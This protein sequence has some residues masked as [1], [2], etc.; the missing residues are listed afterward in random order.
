MNEWLAAAPKAQLFHGQIAC[1]V[2]LNDLSDR[3]PRVMTNGETLD[4]GNREIRWIDTPQVP[5]AWEAGVIYEEATRTLFCGDLLAQLGC[6]P[7]VV[8]TSL[9]P[10][11]IAAE[12]AFHPTALTIGTGATIR[13]LA[14]LQ[15][16]RLAVMHGSCFVGDGE[17]ILN[18][19][20]SYYEGQVTA[21]HGL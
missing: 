10:E 15:P 19:L 21:R 20:A 2:S 3:P 13:G 5:H 7:A 12:E 9:L 16:A 11:A 6:G 4:L 8:S 18:D 1:M 14:S 17:T